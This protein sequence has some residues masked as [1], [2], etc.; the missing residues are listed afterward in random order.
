MGLTE[1]ELKDILHYDPETGIFRWTI[2]TGPVKEGTVAGTQKKKDG[3]ISICINYKEY[4]AHQLA[5]L[6]MT[7]KFCDKLIDHRDRIK[8][9]NKWNNLIE[10][11]YYRNAQNAS[12]RD[13]NSSGIT[14]VHFSKQFQKW[15]AQISK[16]GKRKHLGIYK[17]FANAVCARFAGE[18]C[19]GWYTGTDISKANEYV[20]TNI[21]REYYG[22]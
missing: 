12:I 6:Y 4:G 21:R 20:N 7:G 22:I 13:D 15:V 14:G 18:Q 8:F 2:D 16:K 5:F 11:D 17:D 1:Q 10:T 3:Y 19:L 9:N